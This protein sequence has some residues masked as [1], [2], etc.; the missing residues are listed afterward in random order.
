MGSLAAITN[1]LPSTRA[2]VRAM[3]IILHLLVI[4]G[5]LLWLL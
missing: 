3:L 4:V 2:V 5:D 1:L